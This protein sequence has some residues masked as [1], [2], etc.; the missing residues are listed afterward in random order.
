MSG[1]PFALS[2][3]GHAVQLGSGDAARGWGTP[4]DEVSTS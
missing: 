3:N 4:A 1:Q 2:S